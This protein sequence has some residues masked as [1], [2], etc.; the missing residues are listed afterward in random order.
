MNPL[1]EHDVVL[2]A[3]VFGDALRK[4]VKSLSKTDRFSRQVR[5]LLLRQGVPQEVVDRVIEHLSKKKIL[6]DRRTAELFVEHS[7]GQRAKGPEKL[8][9]ALLAKG[10]DPALVEEVLSR[11]SPDQN[12]NSMIELL[13]RRF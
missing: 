5:D 9:I 8:R 4:A 2:G 3:D 12:L 10:A 11:M 7:C 13:R 1:E 6:D